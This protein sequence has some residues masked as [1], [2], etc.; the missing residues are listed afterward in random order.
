MSLTADLQI[1][2]RRFISAITDLFDDKRRSLQ[3][4]R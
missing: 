3:R 2:N 1:R 4:L